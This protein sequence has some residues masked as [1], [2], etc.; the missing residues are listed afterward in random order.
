MNKLL[1]FL[2]VAIHIF[3]FTTN[4][5][6]ASEST[7]LLQSTTSTKNSGF[8]DHILPTVKTDTN[9]VVHVVAVGTGQAL[10]NARNCDADVL[11]IHAKL[12]E[13]KF[14]TEGYGVKR[15]NLMYNDFVIVGPV[16]DPAKIKGMRSTTNALTKISRSKS[17]F[18]SR[19]DN[20]G[21]H[22]K[23]VK[24]WES[25]SINPT[26]ASGK[27][28]LETG[29]GM[30]ATLNAAIQIGAY[31][32]TDRATWI[33]FKNKRDFRVFV[34]GDVKLFNQYGVILVNKKKCPNVNSKAGQTFI[35][36]LISEKGQNSIQNFR[37][38]NEQLFFPN[39]D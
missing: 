34:Q 3:N 9:I 10:R 37:Q 26:K 2:V 11:L 20:S 17:F 21:T 12:E 30:G 33:S 32:I 23:E 22:R 18:A 39:A 25:T 7:I 35:N 19:S 28:Y 29:S 1:I 27:W 36:W 15:F 16:N 13:K 4:T 6:I 31:T 5:C 8:Y 24:L 38:N 14:V